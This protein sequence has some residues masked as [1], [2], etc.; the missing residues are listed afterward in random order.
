[1]IHKS[2]KFLKTFLKS[3]QIQKKTKM[4]M[5]NLTLGKFSNQI[6]PQLEIF[7]ILMIITFIVGL[8]FNM[9][10]LIIIVN[11]KRFNPVHLLI[12]NLLVSNLVYLFGVPLF[13][14]NSF[15]RSWPFGK[16]GCQIFFIFDFVGMFVSVYSGICD[17]FYFNRKINQSN[18][19]SNLCLNKVT[20]LS[21]ERYIVV[22][23]KKKR[24]E[25][26]SNKFKLLVVYIYLTFIWL[27][28]IMCIQ[29]FVHSIR[30][31]QPIEGIMRYIL[32]RKKIEF[33]FC[34]QISS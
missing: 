28:A 14:M 6:M 30:I 29:S 9:L 33:I 3:S 1:M 31:I 17:F 32:E 11:S 4:N 21:I 25:K 13:V 23:D 8:L 34:F 16:R 5:T 12:S 26:L 20:A 2:Y 19:Y 18:K 27:M 24:L 7:P 10:S 22:T 15:N